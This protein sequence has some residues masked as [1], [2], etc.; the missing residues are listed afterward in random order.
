MDADD[1]ALLCKSLS[2]KEADME[3]A[4]LASSPQRSSSPKPRKDRT[5]D[6]SERM[7]LGLHA[8]PSSLG[9]PQLNKNPVDN[10]TKAIPVDMCSVSQSVRK[11]LFPDEIL[12]QHKTSPA[13][14][15]ENHEAGAQVA[16]IYDV[17]NYDVLAQPHAPQAIVGDVFLFTST[18]SKKISNSNVVSDQTVNG[19]QSSTIR[20]S[21]VS[22]SKITATKKWKRMAGNEL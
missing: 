4:R 17:L 15:F 12:N 22:H 7:W 20:P 1:I 11:V 16:P 5:Q 9:V 13:T 14:P 21:S 8:D 19:L 10:V 18:P 6:N 3:V 2:L